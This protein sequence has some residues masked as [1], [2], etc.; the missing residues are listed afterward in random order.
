[1]SDLREIRNSELNTF[2][3]GFASTFDITGHSFIS[4][5]DLSQGPEKDMQ[6]LK[7]DWI[8]VGKDIDKAMITHE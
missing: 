1:M 4:I 8:R 5:P 3:N 7:G 2:I 6:A